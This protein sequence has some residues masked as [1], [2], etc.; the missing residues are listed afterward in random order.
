LAQS[1]VCKKIALPEGKFIDLTPV[2]GKELLIDD[3]TSK[4]KVSLCE[5]KYSNCGTCGP[6]AGYCQTTPWF[7]DCIGIFTSAVPMPNNAGVELMYD[8]GDWGAIGRVKLMCNPD[9]TELSTPKGES[10]NKIMIVDSKYACPV[11]SLGSLSAGSIFMIIVLVLVLVYIIGGVLYNR[12]R[13]NKSGVDMIP[14]AEFWVLFPS[15][16]KGG[17]QYVVSKVKGG[18]GSTAKL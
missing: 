4:F 16:V 18:G 3:G 15:Y 6:V 10:F 7:E 9:A 17:G 5:N 14:N 12:F 11:T 2:I 13:N 1:E 8:N